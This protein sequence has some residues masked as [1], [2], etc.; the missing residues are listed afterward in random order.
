MISSEGLYDGL[1]YGRPKS[2]FRELSVG[3]LPRIS[4][5]ILF[6]IGPKYQGQ[7][8][9]LDLSGL[10]TISDSVLQMV[11]I[12]FPGLRYLNVD[13]CCKVRENRDFWE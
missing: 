6:K 4:D 10:T 9:H 1:L 13:S 12:Y 5:D 11:L 7:I 3:Y 2:K 8:T